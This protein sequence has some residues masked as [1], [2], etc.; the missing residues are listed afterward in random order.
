MKRQRETDVKIRPNHQMSILYMSHWLNRNGKASENYIYG[1]VCFFR[2]MRIQVCVC[3][4]VC[5]RA[6]TVIVI[7]EGN[8]SGNQSSNPRSGSLYFT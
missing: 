7:I 5:E 4:D 8:G 2:S 6:Y 1:Y 3:V